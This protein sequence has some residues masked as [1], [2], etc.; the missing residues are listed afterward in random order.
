MHSILGPPPHKSYRNFAQVPAKF[1]RRKKRDLADFADYG[2]F[3]RNLAEY[4]EI[5]FSDNFWNRLSVNKWS[6]R[7]VTH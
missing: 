3:W 4:I 7:V 5:L 2:G 1:R 6:T